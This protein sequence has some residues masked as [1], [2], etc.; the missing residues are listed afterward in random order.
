MR[1]K[2]LQQKEKEDARERERES[3]R[4]RDPLIRRERARPRK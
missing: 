4:Q 1:F 2:L 3:K